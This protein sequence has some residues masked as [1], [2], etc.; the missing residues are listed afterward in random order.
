MN[1]S[2]RGIECKACVNFF[3]SQLE[4]VFAMDNPSFSSDAGSW[5]PPTCGNSTANAE[6]SPSSKSRDVNY[7]KNG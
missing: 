2:A 1:F 3:R 7:K 5:Q 6:N 4:G